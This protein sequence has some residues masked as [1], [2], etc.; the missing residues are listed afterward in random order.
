MKPVKSKV[1]E[2]EGQN[3][4][5]KRIPRQINQTVLFVNQTVRDQIE[6]WKQ[7]SVSKQEQNPLTFR[8][9]PGNLGETYLLCSIKIPWAAEVIASLILINLDPR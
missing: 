3:P 4:N 2:N 5:P 8:F 1:N 9:G 6:C 7:Q